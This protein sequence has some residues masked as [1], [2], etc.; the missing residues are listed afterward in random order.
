MTTNDDND[1]LTVEQVATMLGTSTRQAH[2]YG[3]GESARIRTRKAGRRVL[4]SRTDVD[5]LARDLGIARREPPTPPPARPQ[6]VAQQQTELLEYIRE[7]QGQIS[8]LQDEIRDAAAREG[9]YKAQLDARLSLTDERSLRNTLEAEQQTKQELENQIKTK[10]QEL[11]QQEQQAQRIQQ[12]NRILVITIALLV[13][14][15]II[16]GVVLILNL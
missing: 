6:V 2:R 3:E 11:T 4:F 10:Q 8:Q 16:L 14:I 7:L 15:L 9:Y 12:R 1:W 5:K 13:T